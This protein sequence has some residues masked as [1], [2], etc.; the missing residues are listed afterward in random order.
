MQDLFEKFAKVQK[1]SDI[2]I[3]GQL[4]YIFFLYQKG[5]FLAQ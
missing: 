3:L 1:I 4:I 2:S 5:W